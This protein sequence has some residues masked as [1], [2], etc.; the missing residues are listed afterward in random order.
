MLTFG[1]S[2]PAYPA[3]MECDPMS[4]TSAP[5]SSVDKAFNIGCNIRVALYYRY[6]GVPRYL[7][8][9]A[10][11]RGIMS[12]STVPWYAVTIPYFFKF[13]FDCK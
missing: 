9:P 10:R 2:S 4:K 13:N 8:I 1:I 3:R 6:T 11:Y 7:G 12:T 5:T